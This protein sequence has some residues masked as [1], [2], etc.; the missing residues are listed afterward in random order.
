MLL[1]VAHHALGMLSARL[2]TI[3]LALLVSALAHAA[4]P[5]AEVIHWWTSG[6][7]SAAVRRLADAYRSAGGEWVDTAVAG[8]E[9]ARAV[10]ISRVV[11]GNPPTAALFNTSKQFHDLVEQGSLATVDAVAVRARLVHLLEPHLRAPPARVDE[12]DAVV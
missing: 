9:Q 10:A 11:G 12:V 4:K 2:T 8:S 7:E 1:Q 3:A 5:R 6:G